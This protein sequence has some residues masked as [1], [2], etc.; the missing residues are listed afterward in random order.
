MSLV[1]CS[2]IREDKKVDRND[3]YEAPYSF[4]NALK[5]TMQI[6]PDS[7]VAVQSVKLNKSSNITL[8][9]SDKWFQ[10]FGR[11]LHQENKN[12]NL[13]PYR[14]IQ[15]NPV[16]PFGSATYSMEEFAEIMQ[17]SINVG[18][19]HP[20][21]YSKLLFS[22]SRNA[23]TNAHEG[24]TFTQNYQGT[25]GTNVAT[26][27]TCFNGVG[28]WTPQYA[29]ETGKLTITENVSGP[30]FTKQSGDLD[31]S[32]GSIMMKSGFP[33]SH[34]GGV[35]E[36][37]CKGMRVDGDTAYGGTTWQVGLS[38]AML[39]TDTLEN[40][41]A[42]KGWLGY[43]QPAYTTGM[44]GGGSNFESLFNDVVVTCE[45]VAGGGNNKLKVHQMTKNEHGGVSLTEVKYFFAGNP[46]HTERI[47]LSQKTGNAGAVELASIKFTLNNEIL[48][49]SYINEGGAEVKIC[50]F[51]VD[52]AAGGMKENLICPMGQNRWNLY[53]RLAIIGS[54]PASPLGNLQITN[55]DAHKSTFNNYSMLNP[56]NNYYARLEGQ[57][58]TSVLREMDRRDI[59][60][61]TVGGAAVPTY[62]PSG[63]TAK[64][65]VFTGRFVQ[66]ILSESTELYLDTQGA[67]MSK[68]LGFELSPVLA[69]SINGKLDASDGK[70]FTYSSDSVPDLM[71]SASL[72]IRLDNFT[73][74]SI[75]AGVGRPS[76]ILYHLPRFDTS[77]RDLGAGLYFEPTERTYIKLNN[78]ETLYQNS[79]DISIAND[80]EQ[81][82]Y[83]LVGKTIVCLHFRK[84]SNV[85]KI[86]KK[87]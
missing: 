59:Y 51:T 85:V 76:K 75:N 80:N 74:N 87:I 21:I 37:N 61:M 58:L 62:T 68:M 44:G 22:V 20:D 1:I 39:T 46:T 13:G 45:Q 17:K 43:Y 38:R 49:I 36:V 8:K 81:L 7:E 40:A 11:D 70:I 73:Q 27:N 9:R 4:H 71:A 77:N 30:I 52:L 60:D 41:H 6:E 19:P 86:D 67:N 63:I 24:F 18:M 83:D 35:F 33:L 25:N 82:A 79:F 78:S 5:Q 16:M 84:S 65:N 32:E 14:T 64:D 42:D 53:P 28:F 23:N 15:C 29:N 66:W 47:D 3:Q 10:Y 57:G 12:S 34:Q 72:F 56:D 31:F 2:N 54:K 26:D 69:P 48:I 50:D 55:F